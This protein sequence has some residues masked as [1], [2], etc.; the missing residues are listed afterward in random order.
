MAQPPPPPAPPYQTP[1][2]G[3]PAWQA[4]PPPQ[5]G[6]PPQGP[7]P[8]PQPRPQREGVGWLVWTLA[9]VSIVATLIGLSVPT[10]NGNAW[11]AVG[12]WCLVPV[13][14]ALLTFAPAVRLGL[15]PRRAWQ[16]GAGGAALLVFFW[17]LFVLPGVGDAPTLLDTIGAGAG[18]AAVWAAPGRRADPGQGAH[19][20]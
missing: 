12:A 5:Y 18:G 1:Y 3:Q 7:P 17:V 14:G 4:P 13:A 6:P 19:T 16:V 20:W 15:T 10:A 8:Q 9:A 2:G 11:S